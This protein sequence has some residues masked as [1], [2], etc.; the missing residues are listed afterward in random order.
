[1]QVGVHQFSVAELQ[2]TDAN[3]NTSSSGAFTTPGG[4]KALTCLVYVEGTEGV[5]LVFGTGPVTAVNASGGAAGT[6]ETYIPPGVPM[7]VGKG[8][9]ANYAIISDSSTPKVFLHAG[10]GS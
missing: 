4:I 10:A 9:V 6:A 5:Y 1:M 3:A 7:V 2:I 8:A